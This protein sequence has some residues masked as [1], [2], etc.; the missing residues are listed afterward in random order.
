[1]RIYVFLFLGLIISCKNSTG[2]NTSDNFELAMAKTSSTYA[3]TNENLRKEVTLKNSSLATVEKESQELIIIK[4]GKMTLEVDTLTS[5]K[6]YVDSLV[7]ANNGYYQNEEFYNRTSSKI[8]EL[9]LRVPSESFDLVIEDL[10][11]GVGA[12]SEKTIDVRDASEEYLDLELRLRNSEKYVDR[13]LTLLERADSIKDMLVIQDK[14]RRIE[15]EIEVKKG[16][17]IFLQ[18]RAN[19]STLSLKLTELQP[20]LV[21]PE[22]HYTRKLVASFMVGYHGLLDILLF[23]LTLWPFFIFIP[24]IYFISFRRRRLLRP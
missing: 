4:N 21:A 10:S 17:M 15:E 8:Y 7:R 6:R 22:E 20:V 19:Y 23:I 12:I 18:N 13:Y 2:S 16:Q 3:P 24:L 14:I 11:I 1:M 5:A 9:N